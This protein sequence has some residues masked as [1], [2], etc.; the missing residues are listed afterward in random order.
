MEEKIKKEEYFNIKTI[1][2]ENNM[3][4]NLIEKDKKSYNFRKIY[5]DIIFISLLMIMFFLIII[6]KSK[7]QNIPISNI[8]KKEKE[9]KKVQPNIVP[10]VEPNIVQ[11]VEPNV[12]QEKK[13]QEIK[14]YEKTDEVEEIKEI[15]RNN[16]TNYLSK[17]LPR[18]KALDNG[19]S[20]I[21][22]CISGKLTNNPPIITNFSMPVLSIVI[23]CYYC[24][25]YIKKAVRSIQNQNFYEI[26]IIIVIDGTDHNTEKSLKELTEE[27]KRIELIYNKKRMGILYTRSV[28][29]LNAKGKY[30]MTLDQD[31]LF[32][33][34]DVFSY[35]Y[36][37]AERENLDMIVFQVFESSDYTN[38]K[39]Y[40]DNFNNKNKEHNLTI[41]QPELSC[42]TLIN[43]GKFKGN[44]FFIWGKFYKSSIYKSAINMLG[45]ERYSVHMEWEEDVIMTFL[46]V[47]VANSYKF[48]KKYGYL[49]LIHRGTPTS[50]LPSVKKNFYRLIKV[51]IFFD[52]A[53]KACKAAPVIELIDMKKAFN[54]KMNNE[55]RIYLKRL[56]KKIFALDEID[57]KYKNDI[58]NIYGKY[59]PD[60]FKL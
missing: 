17:L 31:D 49:H 43:N 38:K 54:S 48:V 20:Y 59:F 42:H 25:K 55:T 57:E 33:D 7:N 58:K 56:I 3:N 24:H 21:R 12:E 6:I 44:D 26:R 36:V 15:T 19:I 8:D 40:K 30:V 47:N 52:Y 18:D 51:D 32:F 22:K 35:L 9:E 39:R 1:E 11:N 50:T 27:D 5:F 60:D 2:N 14:T 34:Y 13:S 29:V 46:I 37:L 4:I 23:P 41:Y 16:I 45:E 10:N 28:G 53:K